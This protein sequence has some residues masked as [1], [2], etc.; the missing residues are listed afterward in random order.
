MAR[1]QVGPESDRQQQRRSVHSTHMRGRDLCA[2]LRRAQLHHTFPAL[3]RC[4]DVRPRRCKRCK[5]SWIAT[6]ADAQPKNLRRR[7]QSIGSPDEIVVLDHHN[8]RC[9][10]SEIEN[11]SIV[12]VML[13]RFKYVICHVASLNEELAQLRRQL[14]INQKPHYA[15]SSTR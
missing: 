1:Y 6:V 13:K 8:K 15:A 14:R 2:P 12:S 10:F 9:G 3:K 11:D 7:T 4:D 5:Q